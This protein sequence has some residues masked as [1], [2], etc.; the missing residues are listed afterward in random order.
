MIPPQTP[1]CQLCPPQQRVLKPQQCLR[2]TTQK[3][4]ASKAPK[5]ESRPTSQMTWNIAISFW[6]RDEREEIK[7]RLMTAFLLQVHD[8]DMLLH[9]NI[10]WNIVEYIDMYDFAT[11]QCMC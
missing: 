9:T 7:K 8:K 2:I 3:A 10:L 1:H 6:D 5:P 4:I 11:C